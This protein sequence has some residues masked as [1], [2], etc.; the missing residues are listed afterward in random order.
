MSDFAAQWGGYALYWMT[1]LCFTRPCLS[2]H[3]TFY[4]NIRDISSAQANRRML[5][6]SQA[7]SPRRQSLFI[8]STSMIK[9]NSLL[10]KSQF[11]PPQNSPPATESISNISTHPS[12]CCNK[13]TISTS[14][15]SLQ[16]SDIR[17]GISP[18]RGD[19]TRM[20]IV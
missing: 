16:Q 4:R 13:C 3:Q 5:M 2:P 12:L 15:S 10:K 20:M 19:V 14:Q 1:P 11:D 18:R 6:K 8:A 7:E 9:G 17:P